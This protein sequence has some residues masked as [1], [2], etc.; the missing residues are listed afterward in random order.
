MSEGFP[1]PALFA[2]ESP[3]ADG[4]KPSDITAWAGPWPVDE[5]WRDCCGPYLVRMQL[6]DALGRAYLV[7]FDVPTR[8]W[9]LEGVY[10]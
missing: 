3:Y 6:V 10:D 8:R 2:L 9:L 7:C 4:G 1:P 5:R